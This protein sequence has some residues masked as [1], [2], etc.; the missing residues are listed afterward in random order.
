[1]VQF[2]LRSIFVVTLV[3]AIASALL[4]PWLKDGVAWRG[5]AAWCCAYVATLVI[6]CWRRIRLERN[7]GDLLLRCERHGWTRGSLLQALAFPL[8]I[9]I[10]YLQI[11]WRPS[12]VDN[13]LF[14]NIVIYGALCAW[15]TVT[16]WWRLIPG[17]LPLELFERGIVVGC[18]GLRSWRDVL[19]YEWVKNPTNSLRIQL[20]YMR[21]E[22]IVPPGDR[23]AVE[24]TLAA[25][26]VPRSSS[27]PDARLAR[28][29]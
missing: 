25:H 8:L 29:A 19:R 16:V 10:S 14:A 23:E 15:A 12:Q 2:S 24:A 21:I 5:V 4:A 17:K 9:T 7:S 6:V 13:G 27:S 28:H 18:L 22:V 3:A 26:V 11:I 20:H 1:L